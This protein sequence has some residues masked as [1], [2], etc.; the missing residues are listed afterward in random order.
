MDED[1]EL[2]TSPLGREVTIDGVW[3]EVFIY[4]SGDGDWILEV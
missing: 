3:A 4:G 2:V 1:F